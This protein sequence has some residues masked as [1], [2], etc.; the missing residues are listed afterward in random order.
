MNL[1][2]LLCLFCVLRPIF[3]SSDIVNWTIAGAR[4][5]DVFGIAVSYLF[6]IVFL[7]NLKRIRLDLITLLILMFCGYMLIS[8]TWAPEV[9]EVM[10]LVLPFS[11][12]FIA[13][14]IEPDEK[15]L[16]VL[17]GCL[18]LGFIFPV[19]MS[20]ILIV[21]GKSADL[22][23]FQT[24]IV[25]YKG[26]FN[27]THT[28]AHSMFICIFA[29][30]LYLQ[31]SF[32]KGKP[33]RLMIVGIAALSVLAVYNIYFSYTRTVFVGLAAFLLIFFYYN[34]NYRLLPCTILAT[35]AIAVFS[36][37]AKKIFFD[38]YEPLVGKVKTFDNMG[39]GRIGGW[40]SILENFLNSNIEEQMR[41]HGIS[42]RAT[43][44]S[45]AHFGGSH[46]DW[47]AVLVSFGYIGFLLYLTLFC[48]IVL[49]MLFSSLDRALRAPFI[50]FVCTVAIMNLLS[51]SYLTRFE[52]AQYF[53]LVV[54]LF[55]G[56]DDVH[57]KASAKKMMRT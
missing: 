28:L 32:R 57:R 24:G 36:G 46:N 17:A 20:S 11:I 47:L 53:C 27:G 42:S 50:S 45:G 8:L 54:G 18:V 52:L 31:L 2:R 39:S 48:S 9:R 49:R 12:F 41:G 29:S 51:N 23:I 25:R 5:S 13:R 56:L 21:N 26:V 22:T 16:Q 37:M 4:M 44:T 30:L 7:A 55:Y 3:S 19:V 10:K 38:V 6:I 14:M 33:S 35:G 40:K 1:F 15:K 34:R 43:I